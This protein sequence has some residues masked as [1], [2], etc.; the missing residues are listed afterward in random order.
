MARG[1]RFSGF[2]R[3]GDLGELDLRRLHD[4]KDGG[5]RWC[6]AYDAGALERFQ[7]AGPADG[8][9]EGVV[10]K[11]F[12]DGDGKQK[13]G[14]HGSCAEAAAPGNENPRQHHERKPEV[15]AGEKG[16]HFVHPWQSMI[17]VEG[18]EGSLV[19]CGHDLC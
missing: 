7:G 15:E 16:R 3:E 1:K 8:M 19:E 18:G 12:D 14:Q 9:F 17:C 5:V 6:K 2:R 11:A 13:A 10:E 4:R